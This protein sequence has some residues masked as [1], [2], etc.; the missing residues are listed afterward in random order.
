MA[1]A[2]RVNT[3]N[4]RKA[5]VAA[6]AAAVAAVLRRESIATSSHF[7]TAAR[8]VAPHGR[9][10]LY[11]SILLPSRILVDNAGGARASMQAP[12]QANQLAAARDGGLELNRSLSHVGGHMAVPIVGL[13]SIAVFQAFAVCSSVE[14]GCRKCA[15]GFAP[16]TLYYQKAPLY[17]PSSSFFKTRLGESRD[18][19]PTATQHQQRKT[20]TAAREG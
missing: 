13:C 18:P 17:H 2:V 3:T 8:P 9:L 7:L 12:M 5:A 15:F 11:H 1:C 4:A 20:E 6:A 14:I 16:R 10:L 19:P